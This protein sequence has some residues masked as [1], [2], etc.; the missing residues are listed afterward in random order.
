MSAAQ[1]RGVGQISSAV[2]CDVFGGDYGVRHQIRDSV[3]RPPRLVN[4]LVSF[5]SLVKDDDVG[6]QREA[7]FRFG[8]EQRHDL[9]VGIRVCVTDEAALFWRQRHVRFGHLPGRQQLGE[10]GQCESGVARFRQVGGDGGWIAGEI[11]RARGRLD[12]GLQRGGGTELAGRI[13]RRAARFAAVTAT[14]H[15][16]QPGCDDEANTNRGE[17]THR[18]SSIHLEPPQ[19]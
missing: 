4:G 15:E 19:H 8:R 13:G 10:A 7:V 5:L 1:C 17:P 2:A 12:A 11:S 9:V 18:V 3:R 16:Q 14:D 6:E